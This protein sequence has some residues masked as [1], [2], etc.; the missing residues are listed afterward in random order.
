[1]ILLFALH[2]IRTSLFVCAIH[3]TWAYYANKSGTQWR[4][5]TTSTRGGKSL[6]A[7]YRH[8]KPQHPVLHFRPQR[9][10]QNLDALLRPQ[11]SK[12]ESKNKSITPS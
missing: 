4:S 7:H 8:P 11:Q 3:P 5:A 6:R 2:L 9:Q 12:G 1:M 10:P